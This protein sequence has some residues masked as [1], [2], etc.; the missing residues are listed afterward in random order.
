MSVVRGD[1]PS[2]FVP[3]LKDYDAAAWDRAFEILYPI[4]LRGAKYANTRLAEQDA[5]EVASD[6]LAAVARQIGQLETWPQVTALAFVTARRRSIDRLRQLRAQKR[7]VAGAV[8][9]LVEDLT[10][11]E[12]PAD[13]LQ[14]LAK[15][16]EISAVAE[17]MINGLGEP[18]ASLVRGYTQEGLSYE[19]LSRR[20][21]LPLGTVAATVYR[22]MRRLE[23]ELGHSS[24]L[25]KEL[26]LY[27]RLFIVA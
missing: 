8:H 13:E 20:T 9:V 12:L 5:E 24:K 14:S 25:A 21:R 4:A 16:T 23:K 19:E 17:A 15:W 2:D 7:H 10:A 27:L 6:A 18:A 22:S 11:E 3:R 26:A 1:L